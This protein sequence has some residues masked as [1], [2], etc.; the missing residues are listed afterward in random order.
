MSNRWGVWKALFAACPGWLTWSQSY[1]VISRLQNHRDPMSSDMLRDDHLL[2]MHSQW[3]HRS[4]RT[5]LGPSQVLQ[6]TDTPHALGP[7]WPLSGA[8]SPI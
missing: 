3:V 2:S 8:L 7:L 5:L 1:S 6:D 4:P